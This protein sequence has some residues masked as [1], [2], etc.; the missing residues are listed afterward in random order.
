MCPDLTN[1]QGNDGYV[2]L[3]SLTLAPVICLFTHETSA[4]LVTDKSSI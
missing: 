2:M 4:S 1:T 3:E